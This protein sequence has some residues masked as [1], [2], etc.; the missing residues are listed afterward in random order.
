MPSSPAPSYRRTPPKPHS[1]MLPT[2]PLQLPPSTPIT[3]LFA[4]P[5]PSV[6]EQEEKKVSFGVMRGE[7]ED[8]LLERTRE[9]RIGSDDSHGSMSSRAGLRNKAR[10][11]GDDFWRRFSMVAHQAESDARN[12]ASKARGSPRQKRMR[13]LIPVGSRSVA[14]YSPV[15]YWS[16][17]RCSV[18]C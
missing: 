18:Y 9:K 7:N 1:P 11:D 16:W 15:P 12:P 10:N 14:C 3:P 17:Y 8:V 13:G 2:T 4:A 5:P 6:L